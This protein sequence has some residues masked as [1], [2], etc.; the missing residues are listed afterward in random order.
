[1]TKEFERRDDKLIF[2]GLTTEQMTE[3]I[4]AYYKI[5]N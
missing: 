5:R 2:Y 4:K 1:M 3:L